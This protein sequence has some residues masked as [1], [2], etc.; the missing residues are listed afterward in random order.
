MN[1]E[2]SFWKGTVVPCVLSAVLAGGG[3]Y[4]LMPDQPRIIRIGDKAI[5]IPVMD[6]ASAALAIYRAAE[7]AADA[8][9]NRIASLEAE[10]QDLRH[11][12]ETA[13]SRALAALEDSFPQR[14]TEE[15][16]RLEKTT[17]SAQALRTKTLELLHKVQAE[18]ALVRER[19]SGLAMEIDAIRTPLTASLASCQSEMVALNDALREE[20]GR[21][22]QQMADWEYHKQKVLMDARLEGREE[23]L[24][25]ARLASL[26][27][28]LN[29]K[30]AQ[31]ADHE[32]TLSTLIHDI[33][34][35]TDQDW[36]AVVNRL[37]QMQA[38]Q[39]AMN[40]DVDRALQ[41]T[42]HTEE[43]ASVLA[44]GLSVLRTLQ[45]DISALAGQ[46]PKAEAF[47]KRLDALVR[48]IK[49]YQADVSRLFQNSV[50]ATADRIWQDLN[51]RQG[52]SEG[53]WKVPPVNPDSRPATNATV[54][55]PQLVEPG[56]VALPPIDRPAGNLLSVAAESVWNAET[57][58][59]GVDCDNL[60]EGGK[61]EWQFA[62]NS[63]MPGYRFMSLDRVRGLVY[64]LSDEGRQRLID[65]G[66]I[67]R[68]AGCAPQ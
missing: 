64:V 10:N 15:K 29:R 66:Q 55:P 13:D 11:Q 61:K 28:D 57:L 65:A 8:S 12:L 33:K 5:E 59:S 63:Q 20:R 67:A 36:D 47:Q 44:S 45:T 31:V 7:D 30:L 2:L 25:E 60:H 18:M 58:E 42:R 27:E 68:K 41:V 50:D 16:E 39:Q 24:V 48:E 9:K 23:A 37:V 53:V 54:P 4:G 21:Y 46:A 43:A 52:A 1:K 62:I 3:V 51:A 49:N 6:R 32:Q 14:L 38:A 56:P 26:Q 17:Q 40:V 19:E 34:G 35:A 22:A